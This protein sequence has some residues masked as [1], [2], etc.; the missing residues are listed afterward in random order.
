M[1]VVDAVD[2]S[3]KYNFSHS[4]ETTGAKNISI[5]TRNAMGPL[6][7]DGNSQMVSTQ[8]IVVNSLA[9]DWELTVESGLTDG[10]VL[11]PPGWFHGITL[12][13]DSFSKK[14]SDY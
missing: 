14:Q 7:G 9:D 6:T 4:F 5:E 2:P 8:I 1:P 12:L 13:Y 11:T 3:Q 10:I